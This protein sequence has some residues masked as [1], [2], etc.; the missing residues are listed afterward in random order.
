ML[1]LDSLPPMG[2]ETANAAEERRVFA[3][4]LEH[5]VILSIGQQDKFSFQKYITSLRPYYTQY[6]L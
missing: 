3:R 2:F 5:A 4:V 1:E 6:G